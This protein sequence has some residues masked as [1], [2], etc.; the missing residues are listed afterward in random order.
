MIHK[1]LNFAQVLGDHLAQGK[2]PPRDLLAG[3]ARTSDYIYLQ[4]KPLKDIEH[5]I[6]LWQWL[7]RNFV[8][9]K[10]PI[11]LI[12]TGNR[13]SIRLILWVP[14]QLQDYI[15]NIYYANFSTSEISSTQYDLPSKR[16]YINFGDE[17]ISLDADFVKNGQYIDP[18]KDILSSFEIV[19]NDERLD[20][21][22]QCVFKK[23]SSI[24]WKIWK[25]TKQVV[26]PSK[27]EV[28]SDD[29]TKSVFDGKDATQ[30]VE[31]KL[32]Y[33]YQTTSDSNKAKLESTLT[34]VYLKYVKWWSLKISNSVKY[35]PMWLNQFVNFYHFMS[36]EYI[37]PNLDYAQYRKLPAPTNIATLNNIENKND[38]TV[39]WYT[40]Y[41]S[42]AKMFGIKREDKLR[43]MYIVGQ[44]GTGKSKFIANMVRSDMISNKGVC[45]IDPHG[46]LIDDIL[47]QV[48]SY[49]TNDVVLF[50]V[51]DREFPVG[52]N[53]F[54]Y[55][56]EEDKP[57]I[58]SGILGIFKKMFDNSW[59]P[60][61]EYILRN[62]IFSL[63]EYPGATFLDLIRMLTDDNYREEVLSYVK[64]P[65]ILKFWRNEFD[66]YQPKQ[67]EEAVAPITNKVGQF[68]SSSIVRNIFWQSKTKLNFRKMMDEGKIILVNLSKGK[69]GEDSM[70][71][72]GS[73]IASKIQIDA[74][75]RAD[76]P[77]SQR[78][79]FYLYIDEFQNF[80]TESFAT[81]LSEARKYKLALIMAN[82][83]TSQIDQVIRDAIFGNV[84]TLICNRIAKDDAEVMAGQFK[85]IAQ[86]NDFLSLPNRKCYI[87]LMVDG[88]VSDPFSMSTANFVAHEDVDEVKAKVREQSRQR[89]AM[90]RAELEALMKAWAEKKFTLAEKVMEKAKA[91]AKAA[92]EK[93]ESEKV[94][95]GEEEKRAEKVPEK[96]ERESEKSIVWN[97]V[98]A[99]QEDFDAS[100][101]SPENWETIMPEFTGIEVS[102]VIEKIIDVDVSSETLPISSDLWSSSEKEKKPR[103]QTPSDYRT[104]WTPDL[105]WLSWDKTEDKAEKAIETVI[106]PEE[107]Q[108]ADDLR[109]ITDVDVVKPVVVSTAIADVVADTSD[110]DEFLV[111]DLVVWQQYQWYVKLKYNYGMFVTVYGVEWLLH[112]N[113]VSSPEWV[114]WKKVYEIGDPIQVTAMEF[115]EIDGEKRVVWTQV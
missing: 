84:G 113:F 102:E 47:S 56:R 89:Y 26:L 20:V 67:R 87:R 92:K 85:W 72:I 51:A 59:W 49:R 14:A 62:V 114:S 30:Q 83:Y 99:M 60:R 22:Y 61:L 66:K 11:Q 37:I 2:L 21:V 10:Q 65:I 94:K 41:K 103:E 97:V 107:E 46:D 69:V 31:M 75:S 19:G 36:K 98:P 5:A 90:P 9:I 15:E 82:Q 18:F 108:D 57:L 91:E 6:A 48:P 55:E 79:D 27:E 93:L 33:H 7:L 111:D 96:S 54:E 76:I 43:H 86:V 71:M 39:L 34:S 38:L 8:N 115:K 17:E 88:M 25:V 44:T 52:F 95:N 40:D 106:S 12:V 23:S 1:T 29:V 63:L 53:V 4:L 73:F 16:R 28:P 109:V 42:D 105:S 3:P 81:I 70:A 58:A 112:K 80:A 50:D 45:V 24:L 101:R 78:R 74:M 13:A 104:G 110:S 32:W 64:D 100:M 35:K 68:T 77:E